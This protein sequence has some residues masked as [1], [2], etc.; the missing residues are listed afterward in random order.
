MLSAFYV[1]DSILQALQ[2][3]HLFDADDLIAHRDLTLVGALGPLSN[4]SRTSEQLASLLKG[5][6]LTLLI[7]YDN[8]WYRFHALFRLIFVIIVPVVSG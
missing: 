5:R 7:D 2:A 8:V 1:D 4:A 3:V 6:K